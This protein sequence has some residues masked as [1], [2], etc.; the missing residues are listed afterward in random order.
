MIDKLDGAW[1]RGVIGRESRRRSHEL[2]TSQ[3]C[4]NE[5]LRLD[6]SRGFYLPSSVSHAD[7]SRKKKNASKKASPAKV[8]QAGRLDDV[9]TNMGNMSET[10]RF[11]GN[12]SAPL[13]VVRL[14]QLR[15]S[16][17]TIGSCFEDQLPGLGL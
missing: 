6:V 3:T 15:Q 13:S 4:R 10:T 16:T 17:L 12:G 14:C 5:I 2:Q 7:Q 1:S 8:G 11:K 9:C